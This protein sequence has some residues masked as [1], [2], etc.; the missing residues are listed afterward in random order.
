MGPYVL[1]HLMEC[2]VYLFFC[3]RDKERFRVILEQ[4]AERIE[5][6]RKSRLAEIGR[7][8]ARYSERLAHYTLQTPYQWFNYYDFW[9]EK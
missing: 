7:V 5:L 6:S 3:V 1:A 8:A 4:F 2:P 9:G